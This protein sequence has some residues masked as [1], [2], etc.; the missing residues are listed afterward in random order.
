MG[1]IILIV[2]GVYLLFQVIIGYR[3]GF[4]KALLM[5]ASWILTFAIAY[6]GAEYLKEPVIKYAVKYIPQIPETFLTDQMAYIVA[7]IIASIAVNIIFSG[8]LHFV[9]KLNDL[10]GIGFLNK[11]AGAFLGF[12]K[13]LLVIAFVLFFLSMMPKIGLE[14]EYHQLV[15]EDDII[16]EMIEENPIG[17]MLHSSMK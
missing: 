13:G 15:S 14:S 4:L 16:E 11:M 7:F 5:L 12:A 17:Q 6:Y 2:L 10:P 8:I 3:R 1:E 9:N